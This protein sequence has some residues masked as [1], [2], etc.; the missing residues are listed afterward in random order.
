M[1]II[2][3]ALEEKLEKLKEELYS[4]QHEVDTHD[5]NVKEKQNVL[6]ALINVS[7]SLNAA[8]KNVDV[9]PTYWWHNGGTTSKDKI[10][11]PIVDTIFETGNCMRVLEREIKDMPQALIRKK[12]RVVELESEIEEIRQAIKKHS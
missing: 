11:K 4:A 3:E 8:I 1:S 12:D 2:K 10:K 5:K 7:T 6:A 9:L